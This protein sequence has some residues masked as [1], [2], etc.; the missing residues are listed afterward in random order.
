MT[1]KQAPGHPSDGQSDDDSLVM[2]TVKP[3]E[4]E[5][6]AIGD[7]VYDPRSDRERFPMPEDLPPAETQD[8]KRDSKS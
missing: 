5:P 6:T 3:I 7:D 1:R 8:E 4:I 2:P